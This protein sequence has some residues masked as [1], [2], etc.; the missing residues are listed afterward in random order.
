P[1]HRLP[2]W[3]AAAQAVDAHRTPYLP[4]LR[5]AVIECASNMILLCDDG[6]ASDILST[7][8]KSSV[9]VIIESAHG[10]L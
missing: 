1:Q 8:D 3:G 4:A 7:S 2:E 9:C 5:H 10:Y 6:M